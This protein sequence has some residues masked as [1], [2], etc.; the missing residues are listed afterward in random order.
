MA[1]TISSIKE[2]PPTP[3]A[4]LYFTP[5]QFIVGVNG[6]E[7]HA[8]LL[9]SITVEKPVLIAGGRISL[10]DGIVMVNPSGGSSMFVDFSR[11]PRFSYEKAIAYL[12]T[13]PDAAGKDFR[14]VSSK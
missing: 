5:S 3:V 11:D 9:E 10:T 14:I 12:K 2:I 1:R 6:E 13:L 8:K 7:P 4:F